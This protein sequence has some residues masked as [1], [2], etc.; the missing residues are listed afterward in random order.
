MTGVSLLHIYILE[1]WALFTYPREGLSCQKANFPSRSKSVDRLMYSLILRMTN[2]TSNLGERDTLERNPFLFSCGCFILSHVLI[3]AGFLRTINTC[4]FPGQ[5]I[6]WLI[7]EVTP[8][9]LHTDAGMHAGQ[10]RHV[11]SCSLNTAC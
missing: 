11:C 4:L 7:Y 8:R 6:N 2:Y 3:I 10:L 1:L 5:I 9:Y